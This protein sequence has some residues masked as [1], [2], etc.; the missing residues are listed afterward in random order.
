MQCDTL[1]PNL[2]VIVLDN[3]TRKATEGREVELGLTIK[4]VEE[5]QQLR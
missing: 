4:T 3:V 5:N 2:F 1:A